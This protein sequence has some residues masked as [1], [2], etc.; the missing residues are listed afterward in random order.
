MK[1]EFCL[2]DYLTDAFDCRE[3]LKQGE[4]IRATRVGVGADQRVVCLSPAK[5][6]PTEVR[7][8]ASK[9]TLAKHISLTPTLRSA[10]MNFCEPLQN[11]FYRVHEVDLWNAKRIRE[12]QRTRR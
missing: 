6:S 3:R 9:K 10:A 11:V 2:N 7:S 8:P 1:K 12:S 4:K 5:A